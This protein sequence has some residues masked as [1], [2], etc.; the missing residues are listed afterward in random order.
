MLAV[1]GVSV[2]KGEGMP[3]SQGFVSLNRKNVIVSTLK[4][5]DDTNDYVIRLYEMEGRDTEVTV[6]FPFKIGKAWV[7]DM[8]EEGAKEI[9]VVN[10]SLVLKI[11]HNAIET[12]RVSPEHNSH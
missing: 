12:F 1:C 2:K 3:E 6:T 10:N 7:T 4:K 5:A 8:I 9:P 11:G